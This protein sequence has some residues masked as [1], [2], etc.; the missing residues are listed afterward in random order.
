MPDGGRGRIFFS[1]YSCLFD[2]SNGAA[3]ASRAMM[4]AMSRRGFAAESL[5]ATRLEL[6]RDAD[7]L[8]WLKGQG[9]SPRACGGGPWSFD[10][11]GMRQAMPDRIE[12][13][14]SGMRSTLLRT[15]ST[16]WCS[17]ED[18]E[19]DG[20]LQLFDRAIDRFRPDMLVTYGGSRLAHELRSRAKARGIA[21]IFPLHNFGYTS[22][23]PFS[24]VD[25]VIVP[26]KF[27]A[28]YYRTSIG[29]DC[30][31]LPNLVN[32]SRS[33]AQAREPRYITFVNPSFEKGVYI[34]ARIAEELGRL[35]PEIPLLVVEGRGSER[36]LADCGLDLATQGNVYLMGHTHDPR[37][38]WG[39]TK[40]CLL[41]SLWWENQ[42]LVAVEA[43]ANGI[44]VIG[45]NRGGIPEALGRSGIILPI[46]DRLTAA[47]RALPTPQEVSPWIDAIVHLWDDPDAC[48]QH[49]SRAHAEAARWDPQT[50][51]SEYERFFA[52]IGAGGG[53]S[54][55]KPPRIDDAVA[56]VAS[57]RDPT[58]E[59]G[60][61]ARR[62]EAAGVRLALGGRGCGHDQALNALISDAIHDGAESILILEPDIEFD[63][64][65]AIRVL[66]RPES[67]IVGVKGLW[68]G[69]GLGFAFGPE[70]PDESVTVPA[71]GMY[72]LAYAGTE[73]LRIHCA[74][75][76]RLVE[77]L[78]LPL[79][80][81]DLGRGVWPFFQPEIIAEDR[82]FR[83]LDSVSAFYQRLHRAGITPLADT[84]I[85]LTSSAEPSPWGIAATS[86]DQIPGMFDFGPV[87]DAAIEAA[88]DGA[89]FVEVGCLAGRST[90]YLGTKI[91]ESGKAIALHAVD[92][93]RGTPTDT[94]GRLIA[95][96]IGGSLA[97]IL[98]RNLIGCDLD[99]R[100]VVI[101]AKSTR[102]ADLFDPETVD[103]CFI[104]ADHSYESVLA[105][106]GAWWPKI[107]PGG[108]L[109]GHDYRQ[110]APW[111]V[112]V[113]PAVHE[114]FG[115]EDA[116]HPLCPSCWSI[117]KPRGRAR[118]RP[119]R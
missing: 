34:F 95:P 30:T 90:C 59:C 57:I 29:I 53:R 108:Q 27:A 37:R 31:V 9:L 67:V 13:E 100:V 19:E 22:L 118:T 10:A 40:I 68:D 62:L 55:L 92:T 93:A 49:E 91:R 15:R 39:V 60:L 1:S 77:A 103:F 104:D 32:M 116:T 113:T 4:E 99:D 80:N 41:P 86:W 85:R 21:V 88:P 24:N 70:V 51:E 75:L 11:R 25:H 64:G 71:P 110:S 2:N 20:F 44:P 45:S 38:F 112:G 52:E 58:G 46:P 115:V 65:D 117:T 74:A 16:R 81:A 72:P 107:K 98:H 18:E 102:A 17:P 63:T 73:F 89:T 87:Y 61:P 12:V 79:C 69:I 82:G 78:D 3:V 101:L 35:R 8:A 114:F 48:A 6:E 54:V 111:L 23:E 84:S 42:P 76:R 96:S 36:T 7:P 119:S 94:T 66:A 56:V 28:S 14:H 5:T 97:G 47:T 106:I 43:M 105:D 109:A 50:L 26:S 83:Y 33:V